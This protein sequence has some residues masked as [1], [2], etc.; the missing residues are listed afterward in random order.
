MN[1][2][3]DDAS[4]TTDF[5]FS[6]ASRSSGINLVLTGTAILGLV[7][8]LFTAIGSSIGEEA[9]YIFSAAFW[10][11]VGFM[12]VAML[13][14]LAGADRAG[15]YLANV[16]FILTTPLGLIGF[17]GTRQIL[18]HYYADAF[19][20]EHDDISLAASPD[21]AFF[22]PES[23]RTY[24]RFV[25]LALGAVVALTYIL[26]IDGGLPFVL[27]GAVVAVWSEQWNQSNPQIAFFDRHLEI[28]QAPFFPRRFIRYDDIQQVK[29]TSKGVEIS[30][31]SSSH[32]AF[33]DENDAAIVEERLG[34]HARQPSA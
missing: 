10:I 30:H 6:R 25:A 9:G 31:A 21:A 13:F 20:D 2:S 3:A 27:S 5:S 17:V 18:D 29:Q 24:L 14:V 8:G 32:T 34:Q 22:M 4:P 33:I 19:E 12:A 28:Q 11:L 15:S 26:N 7:L 1:D 16:P 23:R